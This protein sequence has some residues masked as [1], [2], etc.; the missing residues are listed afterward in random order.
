MSGALSRFFDDAGSGRSAFV[1]QIAAQSMA[2]RPRRYSRSEKTVTG[3]PNRRSNS[4]SNPRSCQSARSGARRPTRMW[5]ALNVARASSNAR[6]G[7]SAPTV[8]LASVPAPHLAQ[9]RLRRSSACSRALSVAEASHSNRVG[10]AGVTTRTSSAASISSRTPKG[11]TSGPLAASPAAISR[12]LG[13]TRTAKHALAEVA[14]SMQSGSLVRARAPTRS[15]RTLR[16]CRR[17][18]S[19]LGRHESIAWRPKAF[20]AG[21]TGPRRVVL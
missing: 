12:R 20:Q 2:S 8:P 6:S 21:C 17:S 10:N 4:S 13:I 5:S 15:Q 18:W 1:L 19:R 16:C 11:S 9:H 3:I 7:S 14:L